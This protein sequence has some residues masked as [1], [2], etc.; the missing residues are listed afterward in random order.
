MSV[1]SLATC[2]PGLLSKPRCASRLRRTAVLTY[3]KRRDRKGPDL[4][5]TDLCVSSKAAAGIAGISAYGYSVFIREMVGPKAGLPYG[6]D[7]TG[8]RA[9]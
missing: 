6:T 7:P 8:G 3:A 9:C 1:R 4:Q 2:L 5:K